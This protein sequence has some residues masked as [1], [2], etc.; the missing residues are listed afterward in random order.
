[1]AGAFENHAT[2]RSCFLPTH[3]FS[4]KPEAGSVPLSNPSSIRRD[5][6]SSSG[7]VY[8]E[9]A[10]RAVGSGVA[11]ASLTVGYNLT[12]DLLCKREVVG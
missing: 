4:F 2:S 11:V 5:P 8:A 7:K 6:E 9:P 12:A 1:M 10:L 3:R